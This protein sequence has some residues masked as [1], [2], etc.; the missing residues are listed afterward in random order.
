MI[1]FY[2]RDRFS[3]ARHEKIGDA[4]IAHHMIRNDRYKLAF[5]YSLL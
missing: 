4:Q 2:I 3:M 1:F 5:S